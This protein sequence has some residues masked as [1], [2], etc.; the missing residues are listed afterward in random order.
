METGW[1]TTQHALQ[2]KPNGQGRTDSK[3]CVCQTVNAAINFSKPLVIAIFL[4]VKTLFL[5][6]KSLVLPVEPL[7]DFGLTPFQAA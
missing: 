5:A 3:N 4:T 7:F 6:V 1:S 2:N